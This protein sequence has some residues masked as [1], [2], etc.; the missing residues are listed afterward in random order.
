MVKWTQD[1]GL[2]R[3]LSIEYQITYY[4]DGRRLDAPPDRTR[5]HLECAMHALTQ[6]EAMFDVLGF[7]R[8]R[9][10]ADEE[11][12]AETLENFAALGQ[13]V[14]S[15]AYSHVIEAESGLRRE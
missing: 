13:M 8:A 6:I 12:G 10:L 4:R 2:T 15:D 7:V 5:A 1:D 11:G 9:G 3:V 14:A